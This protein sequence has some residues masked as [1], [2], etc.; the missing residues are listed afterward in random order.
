MKSS[1]PVHLVI[2]TVVT[3]AAIM[4]TDT[5]EVMTDI[6]TEETSHRLT[7]VMA[8]TRAPQ[9]TALLMVLIALLM[10]PTMLLNTL[11]TTAELIHMPHMAAMP[12]KFLPRPRKPFDI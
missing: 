2:T 12:S 5:A 6:T 8:R 7:A 11:S 3:G 9:P 4:E 10:R 1:N